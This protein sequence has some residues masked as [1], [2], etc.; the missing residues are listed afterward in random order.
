[1]YDITFELVVIVLL[2]IVNGIFS[3]SEIAVVTAKRVRLEHQAERGHAGAKAALRLATDPSNFLST[4]QVG[5]TLVGVIVSAYGGAT[6]SKVLAA[7]LTRVE[8][9]AEH[10][11]VTALAL[12][13]AGITYLSVILGELVPK[14]IA[15][16][17]PER[18][19]SLV[20]RPMI[21]V[22]RLGRPLVL[23]L[24]GSTHL[25]LRLFGVR[26]V[27]EPGLTEEEIHAVIEQGAEAGVVPE[28]ENAI[29]ESVFRLGDRTVASIMIPRPD[30]RWVDLR[31]TAEEVH[32]LLGEDRREW[33]LVCD[34]DVEEVRGVMDVADLLRRCLAGEAFDLAT[35]LSQPLFVPARIPAFQ[36]L[37]S[38][39]ASRKRVAVVLDEY[40]GVDGIA[41]ID[42]LVAGLVGAGME[43]APMV[44]QHSDG[45][46][47]AA[48]VAPIDLVLDVMGVPKGELDPRRGARTL[49]GFMLTQL[50]RVPESGDVVEWRGYRLTVE[51]MDGRRVERVRI[52]RA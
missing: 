8:W 38:F 42:E 21:L 3:M 25:V 41:T 52:E 24:T 22:A 7:R 47:I 29:V 6:I 15:L 19:A 51:A 36:L 16:G 14:R 43:Q 40:G 18:V 34:G 33:L 27:P 20:A 1:M 4:V 32:D 9:L 23:F 50:G 35:G 10:A 46:W 30:V 31:A 45:S 26:G 11:D 37:E 39:K 5:I 17:N 2:V 12:V 13:V 28:V 48:G 49:S 44:E